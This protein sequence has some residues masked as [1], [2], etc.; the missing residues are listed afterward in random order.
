MLL[1][2]GCALVKFCTYQAF[3]H[4]PALP[5]DLLKGSVTGTIHVTFSPKFTPDSL[6]AEAELAKLHKR[7]IGL[8]EELAMVEGEIERLSKQDKE[9]PEKKQKVEPGNPEQ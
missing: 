6:A 8:V 2:T 7:R 1:L 9:R 5:A 3:W 4:G